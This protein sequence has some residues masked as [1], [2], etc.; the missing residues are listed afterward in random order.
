MEGSQGLHPRLRYEA[1]KKSEALAV[2]LSF[3]IIGAG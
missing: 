1:Q 3:F 2:V